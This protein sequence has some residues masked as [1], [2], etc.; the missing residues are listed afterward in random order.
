VKWSDF[1]P[2]SCQAKPS[3]LVFHFMDK[4]IIC[5]NL[6]KN[7][8]LALFWTD[9]VFGS[10]EPRGKFCINT[11]QKEETKGLDFLVSIGREFFV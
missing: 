8:H 2:P 3:Q 11:S 6:S 9:G 4:C 7:K 10:S 5:I 1:A